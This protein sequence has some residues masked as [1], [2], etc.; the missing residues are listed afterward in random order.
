MNCPADTIMCVE[1]SLCI[2]VK[3]R[4]DGF[5]DCS[6]GSDEMFCGKSN[7]DMAKGKLM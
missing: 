1:D 3:M 6:T 4:C 5:P 2:N 7:F